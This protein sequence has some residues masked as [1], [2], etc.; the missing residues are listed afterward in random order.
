MTEK[1]FDRLAE[2]EEI[3]GH[4]FADRELLMRALRHGSAENARDD[5]SYQR[6]EFLGDAVLGHVIALLLFHR[7][8]EADEGVLTRMRSHLVRSASLATKAAW[9]GLDGWI[10]VGPSEQKDRGRERTAMLEDVFEAVV[11]AIAVDAGWE[12]AHRFVAENFGEDVEGLDED[13]LI[14]A[15]AK[16]ALNQAAQT[17]G[18]DLPEYREVLAGGTAH[19]PTWAFTV[20]WKGEEVARGE[21]STKREAQQQAARR[22]LIRLGLLPGAGQRR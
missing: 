16:S 21:G 6:L 12:G 15:D 10:Q 5:G 9:L 2:L 17:R 13:I 19:R 22:A 11:G 18:L 8:P 7:F 4:T 20:T 1:K 14:L 3:L